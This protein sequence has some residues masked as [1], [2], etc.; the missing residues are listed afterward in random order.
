MKRKET[1]RNDGEER[2]P[3]EHNSGLGSMVG[4]NEERQGGKTRTGR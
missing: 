4:G 3:G 2:Q 1:D